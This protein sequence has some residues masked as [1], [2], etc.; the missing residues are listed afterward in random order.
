[1]SARS[2]APTLVVAALSARLLAES[3]RAAG[4]DVI[5]LDAF[6]DRDT[7]AASRRW[8]SIRAEGAALRVDGGALARALADAMRDDAPVGWVYGAGVEPVLS[9]VCAAASV[10]PPIGNP[11]SVTAQVRDPRRFFDALRALGIAHP[12][13]R[14]EP[15]AGSTEPWLAKDF[16]G[17]GGWHVRAWRAGEAAASRTS[18][19]QRRHDGDAISA[20]FVGDGRRPRV[21]GIQRQRVQRIGRRPFVFR[22]VVGPVEVDRGVRSRIDD[23]VARS[24]EHFGLRGLGS[25]D[26]VLAGDTPLVLEI[27]P[28]PS[29]SLALY[30]DADGAL[31]RLHVTASAGSPSGSPST[32][33]GVRGTDVLFAD[34]PLRVTSSMLATL[35]SRAWC[36]DIPF[37]PLTVDRGDPLCTVSADGPDEPAVCALLDARRDELMA[38]LKEPR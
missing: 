37:E 32:V 3:A 9:Q 25:I 4:Y 28:R 24:V 34:A 7:Q 21:I 27:N 33:A 38:L 5:A 13:T 16:D 36:H 18:Y 31:T 12:E 23:A 1:M 35:A 14:D 20:L 30:D 19:A 2:G 15:P 26:F 17:S 22:G 11:A 29:A 8:Q 6:G 10:P